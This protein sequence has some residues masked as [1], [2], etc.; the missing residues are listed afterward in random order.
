MEILTEEEKKVINQLYNRK[1]ERVVKLDC[2]D[3]GQEFET[4]I[5]RICTSHQKGLI[6]QCRCYECKMKKD[7]RFK[8]YSEEE[9]DR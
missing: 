8:A 1:S 3:C 5:G 7:E 2:I 4:T 6:V 9:I